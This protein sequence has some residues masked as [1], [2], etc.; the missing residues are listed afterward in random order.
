M[1][2]LFPARRSAEE[3]AAAV[4]GDRGAV[5]SDVATLLEVVTALRSH[6]PASP[7]EGFSGALR[8][9][10]ILEAQTALRPENAALVLPHRQRGVR[11]RRLVAAASAFVLIGG[12]ATMAAAAQNALPGEALYPIKRGLESAEVGLSL[13]TAGKG[14]DLLRHASDRLQEVEGLLGS[15]AVQAEPRVPETLGEFAAAADEGAALLFESFR[16]TGEPGSIRSVRAFA[17]DGIET[18]ED[19]AGTV[20]PEAQDELM[21][22]AMTLREIDAEAAALCDSCA[23]DL[24]VVDLPAVFLARAE[25]DRAM[26]L[27]A[28]RELN[29]D[30]AV[31]VR[32]DLQQVRNGGDGA[33]PHVVV[34]ATTPEPLPVSQEQRS[35]T[36]QEPSPLP[37][38]TWQPESWP[39]LLPGIS[40]ETSAG[41]TDQPGLVEKGVKHIEEGLGDVVET[42]LPDADSDLLD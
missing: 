19:L 42:L 41:K 39:S 5:R 31:P 37:S 18:L 1:T 35:E 4:D 23:D 17:A 26:R 10:L 15:G 22:A 2:S 6:D 3:F 7:R 20:P 12:T 40:Q 21:A 29:N 34:P 33:R 38:P 36:P 9:R 30:H 27:A 13:T 11:E 24:P 8:E 16:E 14:E 32:S 25:V 28:T